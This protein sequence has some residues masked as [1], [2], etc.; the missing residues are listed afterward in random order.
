MVVIVIRALS[1]ADN[2]FGLS[3]TCKQ[4][5]EV[6]VKRLLKWH[7]GRMLPGAAD[8]AVFTQGQRIS[9]PDVAL[10]KCSYSVAALFAFL[11]N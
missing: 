11:M 1:P 9:L 10:L 7:C 2:L 5:C 3:F 4:S 8:Q 6:F